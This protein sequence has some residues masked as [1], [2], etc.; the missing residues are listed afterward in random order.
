MEEWSDRAIV[1]SARAHGEGGAVLSVLTEQHGRHAGYVHGARGSR[2]RGFTEAGTLLDVTWKAKVADQLGTMSFEHGVGVAS[3]LLDDHLRLAA[4][5]SA[6]TLCDQSLPERE[7]HPGL[8]HGMNALLQTLREDIWGAA[9]VLWEIALIKE[10]GFGM[11]L[12]RCV[13]GGDNSDLTYVSPK[14]GCAVSTE[15][16]EPYKDKL[17]KLPGF[18]IGK[19]FS[20]NPDRDVLEGLRLTGFFLAH[21]VFAHHSNGVPEARQRFEALFA[22]SVG[23]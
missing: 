22:K 7:V 20:D 21:W 13:A 10:L 19:G 1:L 16:A 5:V 6:C 4:L 9:Y 18:M 23:G 14:S 17:L 11:N 12:T 3:F 2:L 8:F 15:K